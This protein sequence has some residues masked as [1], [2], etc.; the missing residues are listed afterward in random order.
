MP[1][2]LTADGRSYTTENPSEVTRLRMSRRYTEEGVKPVKDARFHPEGKSVEEVK[3]Y[4]EANP[5]DAKR[6]VAE[7]RA[8]KARK[9]VVE[10]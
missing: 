4:I 9:T 6:V 1:T 10:E 5:E 2:F 7:E 8:G 3:A